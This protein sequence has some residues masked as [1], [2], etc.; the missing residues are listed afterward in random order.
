[1]SII[2]FNVNNNLHSVN[3]DQQIIQVCAVSFLEMSCVENNNHVAQHATHKYDC[4]VNP[5]CV[6]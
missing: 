4:L 6:V 3:I 2:N 5:C 1:M